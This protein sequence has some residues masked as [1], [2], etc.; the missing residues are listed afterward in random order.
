M[1]EKAFLES[2]AINEK[3]NRI[4]DQYRIRQD[5]NKARSNELNQVKKSVDDRQKQDILRIAKERDEF[6]ETSRDQ[7][8]D[9]Q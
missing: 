7:M 4:S 6:N 2:Q 5:L 3:L 9:F 1:T 8:R